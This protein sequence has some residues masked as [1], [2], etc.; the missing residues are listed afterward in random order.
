MLNHVE[1]LI[2]TL[3]SKGSVI[4]TKDKILE[5]SPCPPR[6]TDDPTGAGD[7]YRAGFFTA[8]VGGHDLK[9]C[10]QVGSVT[11]TYAVENYGTQNHSFTLKEFGKRYEETYKEKFSMI[12][13]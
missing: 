9:T 10:G 3:G 4:T 7:A 8:Y 12:N 6:S 1:V 2:T 5:I 11:A 13:D